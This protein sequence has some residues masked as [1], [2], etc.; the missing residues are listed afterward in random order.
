MDQLPAALAG[1]AT[2]RQFLLW[3][4]VW[5]SEKEKYEKYPVDPVS[6]E[7]CSAHDP[8]SWTDANT[9]IQRS[10]ASGLGVAFA[11]TS[12][13][14]FFFVDIDKCLINGQ[15]SETAVAL[16][17]LFTGCA[18][19][20]SHS[21]TGLHIF[22]TAPH[23]PHG[24]KNIKLG[25]ELYTE[26]RFVA[27]TGAHASGDVNTCPPGALERA[28]ATYFPPSIVL[29]DVNWTD[30]PDPA[31]SGPADDD[32]LIEKMLASKA[33][34]GSVFGGKASV[35]DLWAGNEEVL[36]VAYPDT[37]GLRP[38]D[39]SSADAALCS[40]LAFWTGK[41]CERMDR[42]FRRSGLFRDKWETREDYRQRTIL[43]ATG[44][45]NAVYGSKKKDNEPKPEY[46]SVQPQPVSYTGAEP[47]MR[48]GFQYLAI[49]Q[50]AELFA[51]CVYVCKLHRMFTPDGNLLRSEQFKAM[52]GGYVFAIDAMN[53]KTTKNAWEAFTESQAARFP[54][55][56]SVCF[57]PECPPGSIVLEDGESMVNTYTPIKTERK[58]GDAT[59][60]LLH[61]QKTLP[62]ERDRTILLAYMAACIQHVGVKF[63]WAPLLQ[64]AEGNG[65]TLFTRCVA[66]A[67]G[68][69]YTHIP[70]A[71]EI[72][73]KFNA[74]LFEKLF[75]G[76]EDVYVPE[77]KSEV[78]EIIK[79]MIT[80]D[81][82]ARRGMQQDQIMG[83]NRANFILNS[84][85]KD[86]IKKTMNDRRFAV[87]YTAQQSK[88]DIERDGMGGQYF[89]QLYNWL[90]TGGY[91]I[92][93][94]YLA[95]YV[96]PEEFNPATE[97]HR[98]PETSSTREAITMSLGG[99]EQEILE[100]VEEGRPGFANGWISSKALDN[101]LHARRDNKRITPHKRKELLHDLGYAHH[102]G[103]HDGRVNSVIMQEGGKPRLY[104]KKDHLSINIRTPAEI[105]KAYN[106]AQGYESGMVGSAEEIF[107]P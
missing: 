74:W 103:L 33:S 51:G 11:F 104:V 102:P 88:A 83:D 16:C 73:E 84:N 89:P 34:G 64:G 62:D 96:I 24:C 97:S 61:L 39:N 48:T 76:I 69:R 2:H 23:V 12:N 94:N 7:V 32:A 66:F 99:I 78:I 52:Y 46:E 4:A 50:Q 8:K 77:H 79:P 82:L 101:L 36:G 93:A 54:R 5:N 13:D 27:L 37:E 105:L 44:H 10:A 35:H 58:Q 49:S 91:A 42:L 20:V 17:N 29:E 107:K 26:G 106:K 86:A 92:V 40:H 1:L 71:A 18:V 65:K 14:P 60:F 28:V 21:G 90:K 63:Q 25:L 100:A 95:E 70:P 57:R 45:C 67:I 22:G 31:W 19:E 9:A 68:S 72:A 98:A 41:D 3:K 80:N 43:H 56:Q 6:L 75:I 38:F 15:W 47:E 81:R 87:F 30:T 85:H 59:P 55:V 53:D